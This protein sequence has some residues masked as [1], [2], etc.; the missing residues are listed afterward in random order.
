VLDHD[1]LM[2]PR[3]L[4]V[5]V[6]TLA[7]H[8]QGISIGRFSIIGYEEDDLTAMWPVSPFDELKCHFDEREDYSLIDSKAAFRGLLVRN[9]AGSMSSFCFTKHWFSTIGKFDETVRTCADL[10]FLLRAVLAGPLILANEKTFYYRLSQRSLQHQDTAKTLFEATMV[11]LRAA[12]RKPDWAGHDL[13]E[14]RRSALIQSFAALKKGDLRGIKAIG[15]TVSKYG[16]LP[17]LTDI[18]SN[19][20]RRLIVR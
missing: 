12:S 5:Q 3:R 19:K 7:A 16:G 11:R 14:L 1:D 10:E 20:M 18:I 4:E 15:A 13:T 17:A 8:P 9:Y 2:R 6:R